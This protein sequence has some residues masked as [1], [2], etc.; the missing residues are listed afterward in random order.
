[1]GNLTKWGIM[2]NSDC[3]F[4]LKPETL[5]H[6]V[7]GRQSYLPR[8]TW[9]LDSVLNF[10]AKTLQPVSN[11]NLFVHL[12]GY[13]RSSIISNDTFRPESRPSTVHLK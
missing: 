8:F 10:I 12:P 7:A 2:S 1:M 3:S 9:R 6:V 5:L 13:K 4:C 11:S